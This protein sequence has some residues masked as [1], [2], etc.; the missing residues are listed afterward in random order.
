MSTA[1]VTGAGGF[2]GGAVARLLVERG[3]T[4]RSLAR[5]SYPQLAAA[6][7]ET[8]R[9]DLADPRAVDD[10]V[11]GCDAVFHVAARAGVGGPRRAYA[12][13][14][15]DGTRHV[16]AACSRHGV[17][18]LVHTSTPSVVHAGRDL[19]GVDESVG[20]PARHRAAYPA[21]KAVAERL[22]LAADGGD[23]ATVA[24]RP[25]L[26]WGPGD[27]HLVP[28]ILARA[29]SGRLRLVGDGSALVD[30]TYIDNAA[31]AHV[32]AAEALAA[33]EAPARGRAYF[34]ANGE[35]A[36]VGQLVDGI[37]AAAGLPPAR[38]GVPLPLALAA[39]AVAE[40]AWRLA[41]RDDDPPVTRFLVR[42]LATA[43]WFDLRAARR[44]LGYVPQVS[45]AEGL[46]R[47]AAHLRPAD[48]T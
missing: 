36:P 1:L 38:R 47:L 48:D 15:I 13:V 26:V 2:I 16:V 28:G 45:T 12:A 30:A 17:A 3:W 7:I 25:H 18:R 5:G 10:A 27:S 19:H 14:N 39:G 37:L 31:L 4:V 42:Q 43:H 21:T 22:V 29:R 6:G 8:R 9:G 24:L 33:P 41:G 23:L 32:L 35:P 46:R 34:I 11:A 44:D 40:A 20:V